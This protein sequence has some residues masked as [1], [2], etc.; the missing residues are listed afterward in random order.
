MESQ[1]WHKRYYKQYN[2]ETSAYVTF[3]NTTEANTALAFGLVFDTASKTE[4]LEDSGQTLV[5]TYKFNSQAEETEFKNAVD[6][7]WA[8]GTHWSGT[9]TKG[10]S[11]TEKVLENRHTKTEWLNPDGSISATTETIF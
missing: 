1:W 9:T 4:T 2:H 8:N 11:L 5:V 3:A 7:A 10:N 6:T